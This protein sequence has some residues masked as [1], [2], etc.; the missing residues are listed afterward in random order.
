M[1]A[2]RHLRGTHVEPPVLRLVP[3]R[4]VLRPRGVGAKEHH[5]VTDRGTQ[6]EDTRDDRQKEEVCRHDEHEKGGA[7]DA[8]GDAELDTVVVAAVLAQL[9]VERAATVTCKERRELMRAEQ[10][11]ATAL[12]SNAQRQPA[13][14]VPEHKVEERL[15]VDE[16]LLLRHVGAPV[17]RTVDEGAELG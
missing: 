17:E 6:K 11:G 15:G 10:R 5:H 12:R 7:A 16:L 14:R 1:F 13:T 8:H 4:R 3:E 2:V 9:M